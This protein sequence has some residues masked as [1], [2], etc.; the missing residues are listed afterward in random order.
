MAPYGHDR[1][2]CTRTYCDECWLER[3][4]YY[5]GTYTTTPVY[6]VT[7]VQSVPANLFGWYNFLRPVV[8]VRPRRAGHVLPVACQ[9]PRRLHASVAQVARQKRKRFVQ[10]LR[11]DA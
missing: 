4:G 7:V 2:T 9:C 6:T 10:A 5:S 1:R 11:R 3:A 8:R